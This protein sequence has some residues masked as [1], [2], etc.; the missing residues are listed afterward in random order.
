MVICYCC[1]Q[2]HRIYYKKKAQTNI[3]QYRF[4]I[5]FFIIK[6]HSYRNSCNY[7]D[8]AKYHIGTRRTYQCKYCKNWQY[9]R[10]FHFIAYVISKFQFLHKPILPL[11]PYIRSTAF[12][13]CLLGY[14][15]AML[16]SLHAQNTLLLNLLL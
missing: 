3:H 1:V 13:S 11:F 10:I 8:L 6:Q 15:Y 7:I 5:Y 2:K 4:S 9:L 16:F 12:H 14:V